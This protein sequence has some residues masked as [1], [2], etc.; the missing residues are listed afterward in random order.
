MR[1]GIPEDQMS[2]T[3]PNM[4]LEWAVDFVQKTF[5]LIDSDIEEIKTG[6]LGIFKHWFYENYEPI[7]FD[8]Y[9]LE[10]DLDPFD[11]VT[12]VICVDVDISDII[13]NKPV[14]TRKCLNHIA[15]VYRDCILNDH[16]YSTENVKDFVND[17]VDNGFIV[18][19]VIL[20][21]RESYELA[22]SMD[23]SYIRF[24]TKP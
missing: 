10:T 8:F 5:K 19:S 1:S 6:S 20:K 2:S 21:L 15:P 13:R 18:D 12:G 14:K 4:C 24:L 22:G 9:V 23:A 3:N 17:Q 11:S 16:L 7:G